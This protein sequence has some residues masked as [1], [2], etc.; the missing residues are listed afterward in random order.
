MDGWRGLWSISEQWENEVGM[1]A[2]MR[3]DS[4]R[5]GMYEEH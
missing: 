4:C 5:K 1:R 3:M 2:D